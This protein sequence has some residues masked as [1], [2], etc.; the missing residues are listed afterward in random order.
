M[1]KNDTP[2]EAADTEREPTYVRLGN[3]EPIEILEDPDDDLDAA[4]A[5][6]R[7][8]RKVRAPIGEAGAKT[9]SE[10]TP[11]AGETLAESFGNLTNARGGWAAH[12]N[13][14]APAWVA[15]TDPML[16]Q[17]LAAHWRCELREWDPDHAP[18]DT[19]ADTTSTEV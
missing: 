3:R 10:F 4:I 15:S 1:P 7:A 19:P 8:V 12:S 2:P 11:A 14:E 16:A 6:N 9:Y 17:L 18:S 5:E 13:M